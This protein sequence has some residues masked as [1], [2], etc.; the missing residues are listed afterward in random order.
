MAECTSFYI[1]LTCSLF[2]H[3]TIGTV[4]SYLGYW[5]KCCNEIPLHIS[6]RHDLISH[7]YILRNGTARS[8][9]NSIILGI[10]T[11]FSTMAVLFTCAPTV[12]K[13]PFSSTSSPIYVNF[14]SIFQKIAFG[15]VDKFYWF[16]CSLFLLWSL[17][18]PFFFLLVCS[19]FSFFFF[20]F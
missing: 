7:A 19:G 12:S 6:L 13:S 4:F 16:S 18:P 9:G 2:I 10:F 11:L 17:S 15:L 8:Y 20:F 3:P 5:G 14:I 1:E